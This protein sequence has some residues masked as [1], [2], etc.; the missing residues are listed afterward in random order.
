MTLC[1]YLK[2]CNKTTSIQVS[3][4]T[5]FARYLRRDKMEERFRLG[6]S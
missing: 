1:G 6:I 2:P 5:M 4:D 3:E